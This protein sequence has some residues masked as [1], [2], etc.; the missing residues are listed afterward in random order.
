[1]NMRM[2]IRVVV[3]AL[4]GA[5]VALLV[6]C[7][8]SG[9]GLIPAADA[10]PL[11]EDFE[12][13][14]QAAESGNGNCAATESALGKTQQDFLLLPAT[15]DK[16]LRAHLEKGIA[17]LRKVALEM[18]VE[19]TS[20]ATTS[21]STSTSTTPA[22]TSTTST[23]PPN[24]T[25]STTSTPTNTPT[26]PTTTTTPPNQSGGT[27]AGEEA[28]GER[29]GGEHAGGEGAAGEHGGGA[30]AVQEGGGAN[31]GGASPGGAQ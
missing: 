20:T 31:V 12:A 8:S 26:T 14:Q 3:V 23:T 29:G 7:G 24:T 1:M 6:S 22:Q 19:P 17:N 5:A 16:G 13:V 15:V 2:L 30:G 9:V 27:E 21:T 10:G 11:Q 4:L 18:C 25:P 28:G